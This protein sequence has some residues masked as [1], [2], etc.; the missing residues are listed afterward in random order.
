M[1]LCGVLYWGGEF[2]R[3]ISPRIGGGEISERDCSVEKDRSESN[4]CEARGAERIKASLGSQVA[5]RRLGIVRDS[6]LC[7]RWRRMR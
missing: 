7:A 5:K 1:G 4:H 6:E 2:G 3:R